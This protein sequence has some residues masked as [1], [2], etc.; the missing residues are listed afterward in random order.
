MKW[1]RL[2]IQTG[3]SKAVPGSAEAGLPQPPETREGQ[4]LLSVPLR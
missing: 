3:E 2:V 4:F 1:T